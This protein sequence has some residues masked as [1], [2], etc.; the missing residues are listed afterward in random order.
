M[1]IQC[2]LFGEWLFMD[3]LTIYDKYPDDL[4]HLDQ[5][6]LRKEPL[7]KNYTFRRNI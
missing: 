4:L 6:K 3:E 5:S 2:A 7:I 1:F